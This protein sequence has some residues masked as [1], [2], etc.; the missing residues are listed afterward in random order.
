MAPYRSRKLAGVK[1]YLRGDIVVA[2]LEPVEGSEQRG[3]ARPCLIVSSD[4]INQTLP[5]VIICPLTTKFRGH[6]RFGPVIFPA[7]VGGL[8]EDSVVLTM[9]IR[10]IDKSRIKR[11]IGSVSRDRMEEL[12]ESLRVVLD[13]D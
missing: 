5:I 6:Y 10:S 1:A 13:L 4:Q 3:E 11:Y 2:N 8:Q 9:Q 7:G 12:A